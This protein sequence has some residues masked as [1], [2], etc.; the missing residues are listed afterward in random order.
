MDSNDT[1]RFKEITF[2][3]PIEQLLHLAAMRLQE[4]NKKT[5]E[6]VH[7]LYDL[8]RETGFMSS[9]FPLSTALQLYP[10]DVFSSFE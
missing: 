5:P 3:E 1:G 10:L 2:V 7:T 6:S 4:D 8:A 9:D